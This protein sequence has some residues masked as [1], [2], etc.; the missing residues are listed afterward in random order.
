[1]L[2]KLMTFLAAKLPLGRA[3]FSAGL[4]LT[5]ALA[6]TSAQANIVT[7]SFAKVTAVGMGSAENTREFL[8]SGLITNK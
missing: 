3:A 8:G 2:K 4:A 6:A 7:C 5:F 1:M